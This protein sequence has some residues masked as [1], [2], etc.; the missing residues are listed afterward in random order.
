MKTKSEVTTMNRLD[1]GWYLFCGVL[2]L[3][4]VF[5]IGF[6]VG[7]R[8]G[9]DACKNQHIAQPDPTPITP[10]WIDQRPDNSGIGA[11]PDDQSAW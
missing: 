2:L 5:G 1:D 7:F 11:M 6:A 4:C 10:W 3:F 8:S 9:G